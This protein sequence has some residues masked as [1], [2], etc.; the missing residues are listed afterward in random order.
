MRGGVSP[1][2]TRIVF[3]R[4]RLKDET[5]GLLDSGGDGR[6]G[7]RGSGSKMPLS[8]SCSEVS[9]TDGDCRGEVTLDTVLDG[10]SPI[11]GGSS[12]VVACGAESSASSVFPLSMLIGLVSED[13][14]IRCSSNRVAAGE[15]GIHGST[16]QIGF[17]QFIA[18]EEADELARDRGCPTG[19]SESFALHRDDRVEIWEL[20]REIP[21]MDTLSEPLVLID[22]RMSMPASVRS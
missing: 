8:R 19:L 15:G 10:P 6:P 18:M 13:T 12:G 22:C 11:N 20:M 7:K 9:A 3:V 21:F 5:E 14:L 16:R 17:T 2:N 1:D 4:G